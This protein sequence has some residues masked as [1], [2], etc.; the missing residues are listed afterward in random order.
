MIL[1]VRS[2]AVFLGCPRGAGV[3]LV[4]EEGGRAAAGRAA[5]R[6]YTTSSSYWFTEQEG[7]IVYAMN[8]KN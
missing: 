8:Q 5:G 2:A 1:I 3:C 4:D 6:W 7:K